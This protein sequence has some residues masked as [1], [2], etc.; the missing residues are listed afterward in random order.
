MLQERPFDRSR[1]SCFSSQVRPK[2]IWLRTTAAGSL[3]DR[4]S[5][6]YH[7][8][9]LY[10]LLPTTTPN[11]GNP[12]V[13]GFA[14]AAFPNFEPDVQTVLWLVFRSISTNS[15]ISLFHSCDIGSWRL[16]CY[17]VSQ[18]TTAR[19]STCWIH[20]DALSSYAM[21]H[22]QSLIFWLGNSDDL[23]F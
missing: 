2:W 9:S 8:C 13:H 4:T 12:I 21:V 23:R 3:R 6:L 15:A 11:V 5:E 17:N 16:R 14:V 18:R 19:S 7:I 10:L 22:E 1:S 20:R